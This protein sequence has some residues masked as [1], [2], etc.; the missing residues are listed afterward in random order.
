MSFTR[1]NSGIANYPIFFDTEFIIYTEGKSIEHKNTDITLPDVRFYSTIFEKILINKKVKIKCLGNKDAVLSYLIPL[2]KTKSKNSLIL[3][4]R[5]HDDFTCSLLNN[6]LIIYTFGYSWENDLWTYTLIEDV[7]KD[8][9]SNNLSTLQ[10]LKLTFK[11]LEK[12]IRILSI[13]DGALQLEGQFLLDKKKNSCGINIEFKSKF[14]ISKNEVRRL[15]TKFRDN[16]LFHSPYI[17]MIV[18]KF[19][20]KE[21]N[22]LIQGHLWEHSMIKLISYKYKLATNDSLPSNKIIQN[23]GLIQF[24]NDPEKYL[25]DVVFNYYSSEINNKL[26]K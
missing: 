1:S 15:F 13:I 25:G 21:P 23:F 8:L 22:K 19:S 20:K 14:P 4:D 2:T 11:V 6:P 3:I 24:K 5:D 26:A 16:I 12:R 17:R 7:I 18:S 10:N 9:T